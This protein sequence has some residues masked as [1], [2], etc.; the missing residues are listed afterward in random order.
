MR[1][2]DINAIKGSEILAKDIYGQNDTVLLPAGIQLKKEYK[3][4]LE[5]NIIK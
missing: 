4:T 3:K 1:K 2:L 5:L